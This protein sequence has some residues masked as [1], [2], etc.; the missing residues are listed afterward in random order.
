MTKEAQPTLKNIEEIGQGGIPSYELHLSDGRTISLPPDGRVIVV[1]TLP[2][3]EFVLEPSD[4]SPDD[5]THV[6]ITRGGERIAGFYVSND[7]LE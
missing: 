2:G 7:Y 1:H 6:V 4:T 5:Q 3:D